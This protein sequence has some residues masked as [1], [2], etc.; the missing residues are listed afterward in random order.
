MV[1]RVEGAYWADGAERGD[2]TDGSVVAEMSLRM[3]ALFYFDW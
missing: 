2:G 1:D 3:K